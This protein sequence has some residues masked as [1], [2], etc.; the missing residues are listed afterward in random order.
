MQL[1]HSVD[2]HQRRVAGTDRRKPAGILRLRM[3]SADPG[4]WVAVL[5]TVVM[6]YFG[7]RNVSG[8]TGVLYSSV[9][10]GTLIGPSAARY[11]FDLSHSYESPIV[12]SAATN[13]IAAAIVALTS[14]PHA[15]TIRPLFQ[16]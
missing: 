7:G 10:F 11:A 5:P 15:H 3:S 1:P 6:G 9:A 13:I 4:G 12:V 2:M 14:R 16:G 8:V